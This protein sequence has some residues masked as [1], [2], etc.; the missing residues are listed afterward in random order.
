M[1]ARRDRLPL[2]EPAALRREDAAAYCGLGPATFDKAVAAGE[3]PP[4]KVIAGVRVWPRAALDAALTGAAAMPD[5]SG[6]SV[7]ERD[8]CDEAFGSA[9]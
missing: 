7:R 4:A 2:P 1:T 3:L 9:G 5:L 8:R 6:I